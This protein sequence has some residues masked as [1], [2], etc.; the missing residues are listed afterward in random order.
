MNEHRK[1][2]LL[3]RWMDDA[4]SD[5]ELRELEPLLAAEPELHEERARFEALREE[6]KTAIPAEEEPPYP[7]FFNTHL[8][9]LI[10]GAGLSE[11]ESQPRAGLVN[12]IWLWWMA[13][14]ATA[15]VVVAF[16]LGMKSAQPEN[17]GIVNTVIES[18]VYSPMVNVSTEVFFDRESEATLLV[19]EGLEP[20]GDDDLSLGI[21]AVDGDHGYFVNTETIY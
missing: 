3:A 18:E 14:A 4:L 2:E 12:R 1:E 21:G 17:L 13:P 7:D 19:V 9:R 11:S 16:L 6:L 15:A 10:K 20:L 5:E 8:E